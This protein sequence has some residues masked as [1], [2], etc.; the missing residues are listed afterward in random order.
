M[1]EVM[2]P[3]WVRPESP[4]TIRIIDDGTVAFQPTFG[5]GTTQRGIFA[6]PRW[7]L[8]RR[9]RGLR[10]DE[11]AAILNALNETRGQFNVLRVTPHAPIRGSFPTSEILANNTFASGTTGWSGY[12]SVSTITVSD[13]IARVT[14][15]QNNTVNGM[16]LQ[17][18]SAITSLVQYAPYVL[19]AMIAAGRNVS[20]T[21]LLRLGTA[22]GGTEFGSVSFTDLGYRTL[23]AVPYSVSSVFVL[24]AAGA[25][26]GYQA[27]DYFNVP[28]ISVARCALIDNGTNLSQRSDEF[29][30][31]YWTKSGASISANATA[32]PD[33]NTAA[34]SLVENS[35]TSSHEV[36]MA[37]YI[38]ISSAV[39][40]YCFGIAVKAGTRTWCRISMRESASSTGVAQFFNLSTGA[41]GASTVGANWASLRAFSVNLGNGWFGLWIVARKTNAAVGIAA[42]IIMST[43]DGTTS[44]AGNGT[45]NIYLWRATLAQSSVPMRL[46][47]TTSAAY[48][49]D[50]QSGGALFT[51]GW[52][53]S[54]NA[55]L[56]A[57]DWIEI[58]GELK[59][60]TA[61]VNSNA[62][63]LAYM[64][65]RPGLAGTPADNDPIIV[66]EPF[67]RFI[68]PAGTREIENQF[69]IYGDCTMDLEEIYV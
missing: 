1:A 51:K 69:G 34:D 20:V 64:Q 21:S 17:N 19:R 2:I 68:Y 66:Y 42:D 6:D 26:A 9:Y 30:N 13:R 24:A 53:A 65:F 43:A 52:P 46:A 4:E 5:R 49:G 54:T 32:A 67:G 35:A 55:L 15:D 47:Q 16:G 50:S 10:S 45:G 3:P 14:L 8:R 39:A 59:Q 22:A 40:D 60:L 37:S 41:T 18:S 11:K 25:V 33:G 38:T 7:G 29:D 12:Q 31:A 36:D 23:A 28:Y 48:T 44:Y 58:N 56:L 63:G 27:G 57:G 61:P 62:A